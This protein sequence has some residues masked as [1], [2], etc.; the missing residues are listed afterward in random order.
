MYIYFDR[1]VNENSIHFHT[2]TSPQQFWSV[3]AFTLQ[4]DG[5]TFTTPTV[6]TTTMTDTL[7]ETTYTPSRVLVIPIPILTIPPVNSHSTSIARENKQPSLLR[8][9][10][11]FILQCLCL[12]KERL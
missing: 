7:T 3:I 2:R 10:I 5:S 11:R 9:Y 6:T 12:Y 1:K 8:K 4:A